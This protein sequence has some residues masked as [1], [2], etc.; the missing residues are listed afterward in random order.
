MLS[1]QARSFGSWPFSERLTGSL[2]FLVSK[3]QTLR[4][5]TEKRRHDPLHV[6]C[7]GTPQPSRPA[8]TQTNRATALTTQTRTVH[9]TTR[10]TRKNT[11][12]NPRQTNNDRNQT[13]NNRRTTQ[14]KEVIHSALYEV[15]AKKRKRADFNPRFL[16][17]ERVFDCRFD[18]VDE[19]ARNDVR[20]C[21]N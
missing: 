13:Q 3:V 21:W 4:Q 17:Y 1:W 16:R 18:L 5:N 10:R 7:F 20:A 14:D 6:T 8:P 12:R 11:Q 9:R 15:K 2:L 19:R